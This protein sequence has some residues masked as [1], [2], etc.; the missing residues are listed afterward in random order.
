MGTPVLS[1]I[2]VPI[3]YGIYFLGR[4]KDCPGGAGKGEDGAVGAVAR[5]LVEQVTIRYALDRLPERPEHPGVAPLTHVDD[6]FKAGRLGH[7]NFGGWD[8]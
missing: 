4:R 5:V 3:G 8:V 7:R 2:K 6:A 1:H